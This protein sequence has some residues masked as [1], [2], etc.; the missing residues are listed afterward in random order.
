MYKLQI[1]VATAFGEAALHKIW[2]EQSNTNCLQEKLAL[3]TEQ[4]RVLDEKDKAQGDLVA[5]TKRKMLALEKD[6]EALKN[7][8]DFLQR[9][10][11]EYETI[12]HFDILQLHPDVLKQ[13]RDSF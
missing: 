6:I 11:E 7:K 9:S 3:R 13:I 4:L 1:K 2:E 10:I 12:L 5:V 8:S